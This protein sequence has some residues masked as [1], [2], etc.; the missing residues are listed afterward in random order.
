MR[1]STIS[2]TLLLSTMGVSIVLLALSVCTFTYHK[3]EHRKK[4]HKNTCLEISI[5]RFKK[6]NLLYVI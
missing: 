1:V 4:F 5:L 3:S 2:S 6:R